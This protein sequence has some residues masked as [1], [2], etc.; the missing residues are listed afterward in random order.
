M[1]IIIWYPCDEGMNLKN[2]LKFI[3]FLKIFVFIVWI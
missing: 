2:I 3:G 1:V